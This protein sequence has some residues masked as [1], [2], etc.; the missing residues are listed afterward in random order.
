MHDWLV[1]QCKNHIPAVALCLSLCACF[2]EIPPKHQIVNLQSG[3][4]IKFV[5]T[6]IQRGY[7]EIII[8]E[9]L[10]SREI[11]GQTIRDQEVWTHFLGEVEN[12]KWTYGEIVILDNETYRTF[13]R[14]SISSV[15]IIRHVPFK[16]SSDGKW[17]QIHHY[18]SSGWFD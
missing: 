3:R 5:T 2:K 6:S 13:P 8:F 17:Q 4:Q 12:G 18:Y 10:K 11:E 9:P 14:K 15:G 16:K 1:T 7:F